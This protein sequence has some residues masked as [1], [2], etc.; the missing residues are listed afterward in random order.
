M[1]EYLNKYKELVDLLTE[2]VELTVNGKKKK[3]LLKEEF[4]SFFTKKNKSA[5]P[6]IR[7]IMQMVRSKSVEIREDIQNYKSEL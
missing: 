4:E 6:R 1:D 5:A 2:E 7:K 3:Y